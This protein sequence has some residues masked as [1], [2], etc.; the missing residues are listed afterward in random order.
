MVLALLSSISCQSCKVPLH[1]GVESL[2][3]PVPILGALSWLW[4]L[5]SLRG[6]G[7][8]FCRH[9]HKG[10]VVVWLQCLCGS[11]C[12]TQ[13]LCLCSVDSG[14]DRLS[15]AVALHLLGSLMFWSLAVLPFF[16]WCGVPSSSLC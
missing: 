1:W 13:G 14:R 10:S 16:E 8:G 5:S 15:V 9:V 12:L 2:V 7:G 3:L 6:S 11:V 4:V